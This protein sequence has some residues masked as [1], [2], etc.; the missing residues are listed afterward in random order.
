MTFD[1]LS[2]EIKETSSL[3]GS[4]VEEKTVDKHYM[5]VQNLASD[6]W[7]IQHNLNKY[8]SVT[9]IDSAGSLIICEIEYIDGNNIALRMSAPFSGVAYLN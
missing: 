1:I 9:V 8:P 2:G 4:L 7:Q 6:Y 5:H 3:S